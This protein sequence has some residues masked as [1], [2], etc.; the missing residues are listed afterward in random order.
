M[1]KSD[2]L[3]SL[4][5]DAEFITNHLVFDIRTPKKGLVYLAYIYSH[6]SSRNIPLALTLLS[7]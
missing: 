2:K 3:N 4:T 5:C 6:G 7:T 1:R